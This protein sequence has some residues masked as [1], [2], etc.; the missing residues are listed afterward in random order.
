MKEMLLEIKS[1]TKQFG[2]H[3]TATV[4]LN[5][6]SYSLWADE[7]KT[8]AVVGESG[9]GKSTLANL[10]LAFQKPSGGRILY[11][12]KD[13]HRM[14]R[15]ERKAY[16]SEVQAIFQN[17]FDSFNPFYTV[18]HVFDLLTEKFNIAC[19]KAD[20]R[21]RIDNALEMVKLDPDNVHGKYAFQ[22]S[23]GQLQR[24]MIARCLLLSP[25]LLVADEP[26]SMIDAS[27]R[28]SVLDIMEKIKK[29]NKI[30]QIYITHD[31]STAL[32]ISDDIIVMYKGHIVERGEAAEVIYNPTHPYTRMLIKC[33][34]LPNP[35]ERWES[36]IQLET[37]SACAEK[38]GCCFYGRC[39]NAA[40]AC[41]GI[42]PDLLKISKKHYVACH[43]Y[44]GNQFGSAK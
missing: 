10:I 17:P 36:P 30:S 24:I 13:I 29:E 23:G 6:V 44:D 14:S 19:S 9:S 37:K 26:V 16:R 41:T 27:L 1:V 31:L 25:K 42:Q 12:G 34:P 18:D 28:I 33:I 8:L 39:R 21:R 5:N 15:A 4:A 38:E 40:D 32:Q 35:S 2:S 43:L 11:K 20:A 3:K 22:L 7:T